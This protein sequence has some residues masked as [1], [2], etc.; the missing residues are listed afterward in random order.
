MNCDEC[1]EQVFELI[2]R[3]AI[4]PEG[5]RELLER[6]PECRASFEEVKEALRSVA[7]LAV[8]EPPAETDA[9]ILRAARAR[10]AKV[11]PRR[12]RWFQS[13]QWAV[14][15]VALL[16]VGVG[17]WS[18]PR[19]EEAA[20]NSASPG[21]REPAVDTQTAGRAHDKV[22]IADAPAAVVVASE[23]AAVDLDSRLAVA[24]S[25]GPGSPVAP[26]QP[27]AARP[28]RK[29]MH[30]AEAPVAK[31]ASASAPMA[32]EARRA[33]VAGPSA[34]VVALEEDSGE[35]VA[36]KQGKAMSAECERR[37]SALDALI[38]E[39]ELRAAGLLSPED[40]LALGRC[41][42]EA[43]DTAEARLW[44]ELAASDPKTKRRAL[45]ALKA[46]PAE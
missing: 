29:A 19:G 35:P 15:A 17:V 13:P 40:A 1:Q 25:S 22:E 28:K 2:E 38:E 42:Q 5:V 45:R 20:M 9:A 11:A 23:V 12:R 33:F 21:Q 41:Y 16:A 8:E 7:A 34:E 39:Q 14:A 46:L 26:P 44:L 18:I 31:E 43:G 6:C 27:R 32:T 3:E 24:G 4:D 30:D 10:S 37:V 36:K